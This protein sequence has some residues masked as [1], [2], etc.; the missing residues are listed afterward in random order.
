MQPSCRTIWLFL[1]FL[2]NRIIKQASNSTS[3]CKELKAG[4]QETPAHHVHSSIT[5]NGQRWK[6]PK[7]SS[8][9]RQAKCGIHRKNFLNVVY[10]CNGIFSNKKMIP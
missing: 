5:H 2:K 1:K 3:G 9:I 4:S 7:C 6:Q 8:L 10:T